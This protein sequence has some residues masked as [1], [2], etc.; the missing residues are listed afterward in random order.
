[1]CRFL[2]S[3]IIASILVAVSEPVLAQQV[4]DFGQMSE[5]LRVQTRLVSRL[6]TV[7]AFLAGVFMTFHGVMKLKK[8]TDNPNDAS[9]SSFVAFSFI[10]IGAVMV[11]LPALLATGVVTFFGDTGGA[12]NAFGA[13][14]VIPFR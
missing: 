12:T 7:F 5:H 8:H 11:A 6:V 3:V 1:M 4:Q 9:A 13:G 2:S 14:N 10:I